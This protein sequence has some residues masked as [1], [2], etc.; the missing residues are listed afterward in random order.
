MPNAF[1]LPNG[2]IYVTTGLLALMDNESQVA[3]IMAHEMTHIMRRHTYLQNR[4]NRKKF[5]AI[6]IIAVGVRNP[7]G[8]IPARRSIITAV[9]P[10][11]V[12]VTMLG[13]AAILERDAD[14]RAST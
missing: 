2:S 4:S 6:N 10:L 8:G 7:L 5:L 11:I 9:A 12:A 13:T 1:A 3:A 14:Q